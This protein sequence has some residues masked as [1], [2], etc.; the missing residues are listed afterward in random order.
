MLGR[1]DLND[2]IYSKD[3]NSIA[4]IGLQE[5][6]FDNNE[7]IDKRREE[8]IDG[9]FEQIKG[10]EYY[11]Y[12]V[13]DIGIG[14]FEPCDY[15]EFQDLTGTNYKVLVLNQNLEITSG[16]TGNSGA[17]VPDTSTTN[18]S[19]ASDSQKR[20]TKTEIQVNKQDQIITTTIEKQDQ[21]SNKLTNIE[22]DLDGVKTTIQDNQ[23]DVNEKI[24]QIEQTIEGTAQTL[25]TKG[26]N[27]IFYYSEAYWNDGTEEGIANL[28]EY[29]DTEIQQKS[30]SKVGYVINSGVSEQK[31]I[32]KNDTY[33]ISFT[34]KKILEASNCYVE[35]NG[36]QYE[37]N[38]L[39]WEQFSIVEAIDTNTV[40]VK[41]VS[42]TDGALE[43][44]DLV[45]NIGTERQ[46]WTQNPNEVRTDTVTIGKGI[47]INSSSTNTYAR[48][49]ADGNRIYNSSTNEVVT[50]L[51][52]K[53]VDTDK[54]TADVGQIGGVLIQEIDE[55][56]WIS[57]LL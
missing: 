27:N 26:G 33:A 25:T 36:I 54:V 3:N 56:T 52:D 19:Y 42:D 57:S 11:A 6:K 24:N 9:M 41:F 16:C 50:E 37:L 45:G 2:N 48:F 35:I 28:E 32:V 43:V 31:V 39:D 12:E 44:F 14:I 22:A 51:T 18:Y 23:A 29:T 30:V 5:I 15:T 55:Q 34:Y 8:V 20:I 53:G 40:D 13:S 46:I 7:I 47:Q 10:L 21:Q 17:N 38:S 4:E 1:G 49:D